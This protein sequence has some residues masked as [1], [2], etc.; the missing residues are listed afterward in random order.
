MLLPPVSAVR[1]QVQ[2]VLE[3]TESIKNTVEEN[4]HEL[5]DRTDCKYKFKVLCKSGIPKLY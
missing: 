2:V 5:T 3:Q 4:Y 1:E